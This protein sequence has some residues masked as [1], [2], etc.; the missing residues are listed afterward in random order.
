[1]I[2]S[3]GESSVP[4]L[5]NHV[6][7][8]LTYFLC[9]L[10]WIHQCGSIPLSLLL[11]E[12]PEI[13]WFSLSAVMTPISLFMAWAVVIEGISQR[14][15]L[16]SGDFVVSVSLLSSLFSVASLSEHTFLC[17]CLLPALSAPPLDQWW[18]LKWFKRK[19]KLD[20][21]IRE[22]F[23]PQRRA[24]PKHFQGTERLVDSV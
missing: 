22:M 12:C 15:C 9:L 6:L 8:Y 13:A 21:D 16:F 1:M 4:A 20:S 14:G 11:R 18:Y 2:V 10:S 23:F 17:N 5:P 19:Q 24:K 3:C 7:H